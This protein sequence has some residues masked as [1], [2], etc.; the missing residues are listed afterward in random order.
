MK[1]HYENPQ[2]DQWYLSLAEHPEK[3][4]FLF[5]YNHSEYTGFAAPQFTLK[6]KQIKTEGSKETRTFVYSFADGL[7]ISLILTH[8]FSHGVTEWTVWFEN[9]G[10]ENSGILSKLRTELTFTGTQPVLKGILGDHVNQYTPY[11]MDLAGLSVDFS[12]DSGRATHINFPYFNLEYGSGGVM[13][14]IGWA[15]TWNARFTCRNDRVTYTANAVN[16]LH[17]YLKPGEKIRTALFVT[18]PYTVRNEQYATNFWRSWFIEHNLPKENA[19]GDALQ[20]LPPAALPTTPACPIPTA[21]SPSAI[22]H[23]SLRWIR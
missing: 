20:P 22:P 17:T 3:I 13:L 8:Y 19:A 15:G 12:S 11:N 23:G 21:A 10:T 7:E 16:G 14:A 18:A 5:E 6:D 2:A 4:P 9:T 1:R